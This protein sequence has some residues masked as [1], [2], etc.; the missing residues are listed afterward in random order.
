[1]PFIREPIFH[2]RQDIIVEGPIT[3][4]STTFVDIP[5]AQFITAELGQTGNYQVWL[6]AG[7]EQSSN[8]SSITFRI[9]IDGV[10]G[11][12]RTVNFGPSSANEPQHATLIGQAEDVVA[13]TLVEFQWLVSNGTGQIN[14]LRIMIDGIP[15][16]R[17]IP[18]PSPGVDS[19]LTEAGDALLKE[20]GSFLLLEEQ[21]T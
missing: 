11:L 15:E 19:Y 12:G 5:G 4:T 10:P 8:N 7:I 16:S 21:H 3:T 9:V 20:D 6:S 2:D 13:D 17:V 1:M 14:N 18:A